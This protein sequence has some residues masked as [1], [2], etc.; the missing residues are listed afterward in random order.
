MCLRIFFKVFLMCLVLWG[1]GGGTLRAV[2][3]DGFDSPLGGQAVVIQNGAPGSSSTS[4]ATALGVPGDIRKISIEVQSN[5]PG[6]T[7]TE[8]AIS[9]FTTPSTYQLTQASPST[10]SVSSFMMHPSPASWVLISICPA[11]RGFGWQEC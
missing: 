9:T 7:N 1:I 6:G 8:A 11:L 10:P 3:I 4:I 2:T 5:L